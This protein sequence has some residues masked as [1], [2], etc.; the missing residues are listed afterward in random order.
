[1]IINIHGTNI[2]LTDALRQYAE[3]KV[4]SLTKYFDNIMQADIDIGKRSEHHNKGNIF[5]AE[6]NLHVPGEILRSVKD[7]PDV[8]AS[9]DEVKDH[10]KIELEKLKGKL[11]HKDK[12]GLREQKGY[13]E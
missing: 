5:Y 1:M 4:E 7:T 9:I 10:L 6:V 2:D 11:R 12:A 3:E 13:Q 8:Y